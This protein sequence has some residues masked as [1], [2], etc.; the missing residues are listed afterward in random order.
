[1]RFPLRYRVQYFFLALCI[2]SG[3]LFSELPDNHL[4]VIESFWKLECFQRKI[5]SRV[6]GWSEKYKT[7]RVLSAA[8][9]KE[10][11][12]LMRS[13]QTLRNNAR[14]INRVASAVHVK[15]YQL[16]KFHKVHSNSLEEEVLDL[17]AIKLDDT[18]LFHLLMGTLADLLVY[19]QLS[20]LYHLVEGD[21]ILIRRLN[22]IWIDGE[23]GHF[24][25]LRNEWL[26]VS[27][28]REFG[29]ALRLLDFHKDR[30]DQLIGAGQPFLIK[31]L[32]RFDNHLARELRKSSSFWSSIGGFFKSAYRKLKDGSMNS[33]N[34]MEY[35]LSKIFGN[36]SGAVNWQKFLDSIP[37]QELEFIRDEVLQPGDIIVEKTRGALTDTLIPGFFGHLAMVIGTPAQLE[38]IKLSDGSRILD[39]PTIKALIPRLESGE[40]VVESIRPGVDLIDIKDWEIS[41]L[42]VIRASHYPPGYLGEVILKAAMYGGRKYDFLFDINTEYL[43]ICSEI[44]FHSYLGIKFRVSKTL[45]IWTIS[46]DDVA[47]LVRSEEEGAAKRP[48]KL[49]YFFTQK[50]R[51][52]TN[53]M[54]GLYI[55]ALNDAGSTYE[56][57]PAQ[58][59]F[60]LTNIASLWKQELA[61]RKSKVGE[62]K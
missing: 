43:P 52:P 39:H 36:T 59:R 60:K 2:C 9:S 33:L 19:E 44:P 8:S 30:F 6:G 31:L 23:T 13:V 34:W 11:D 49:I 42:A 14:E 61:K 27:K 54:L 46:P 28:R 37:A 45:G 12:G 1:M 21:R 20:F 51:I 7:S 4:Q 53:E 40:T 17:K 50:K 58:S 56:E 18:D 22:E 25:K 16:E 10:L 48:L 41:D 24:L 3:P 55:Q 26:S 47:V 29:R 5:L 38:G 15:L 32:A 57:V 62:R 35:Q